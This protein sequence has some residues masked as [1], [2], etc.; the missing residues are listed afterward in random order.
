MSQQ[1]N[2]LST[3]IRD[4]FEKEDFLIKET[5]SQVHSFRLT[6]EQVSY[7][8]KELS[9]SVLS[10]KESIKKGVEELSILKDATA[11]GDRV[12][13]ELYE[14]YKEL[15]VNSN[16]I[17]SVLNSVSLLSED[18]SLL[19]I[20]AAVEASKAGEDGE[21]FS[22]IADK[23]RVL[24]SDTEEKL[25]SIDSVALLMASLLK[26]LN[27]KIENNREQLL[28]L[29]KRVSNVVNDMSGVANSTNSLS[30]T[31]DSFI[32]QSSKLIND[33]NSIV[34]TIESVDKLS[35]E[36]KSSAITVYTTS[37]RLND[38]SDELE[39][40]LKRFKT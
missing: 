22:I 16:K 9:E 7:A 27:A 26:D 17:K 19:A 33:S 8:L 2:K 5:T 6:I 23:M 12:S 38:L 34:E 21:G 1:L 25:S 39:T 29:D 4:K 18:V 15:L 11:D 24:S 30:E 10:S 32:G 37:V 3:D 20:N 28:I 13:G 14:R 36:N 40:E 35:S 31:V